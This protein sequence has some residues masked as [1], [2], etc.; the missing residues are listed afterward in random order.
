MC[1]N[2]QIPMDKAQATAPKHVQLPIARDDAQP[3][4]QD[5]A[6]PDD[7]EEDGREVALRASTAHIGP[8][9][10]LTRPKDYQAP[11]EG[12]SCYDN[13]ASDSDSPDEN[14]R[15]VSESSRCAPIAHPQ[16][17]ETM[18]ERVN[19]NPPS[20][21]ALDT[22]TNDRPETGT[23][24]DVEGEGRTRAAYMPKVA[25]PREYERAH[26]S[27]TA[28]DEAPYP[29]VAQPA[30]QPTPKGNGE[31]IPITHRLVWLHGNSHDIYSPTPQP[32]L[33]GFL[34]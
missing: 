9:A 22:S 34:H 15:R 4:T 24:P 3:L 16:Y 11:L 5:D 21:H 19:T 30:Y 23:L 28:R 8:M 6:Q 27:G 26:K 29:E 20:L 33:W 2:V 18:R 31:K 25:Q 10:T 17:L 32:L 12:M 13:S 7:I 14:S 1:V